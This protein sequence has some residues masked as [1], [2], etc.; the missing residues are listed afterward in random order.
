MTKLITRPLQKAYCLCMSQPIPNPT[1]KHNQSGRKHLILLIE[2]EKPIRRFVKPYLESK[3]FKVV[4]A[5]TGQ[6]GLS[7]ASSHKPDLILL[8][9]GLPDMDGLDVLRRLREWTKIPV[10]ILSARGKDKEKVE[11]L[12][13]GADDYLAKPFSV[14]E[15]MARI[16]VSLRH[17]F[18]MKQQG[19]EPVFQTPD[20]KV[21]LEARLVTVR[22]KETHLT[23]NEYEILAF[24]IRN[25]GK[26]VT[27]KQVTEE[28]WG[29]HSGNQESALRLYIHQLR[30]KLEADAALP[31]YILT[32]PG[33]GYRLKTK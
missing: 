17:L 23:P 8:D 1:R 33:V 5:V 20:F 26:V 11:G 18:D 15:L 32:E 7:L 30:Q 3:D 2:D 28:V 21:D 4:E 13:A 12:E 25:A 16:G 6:E 19:E 9:L 31:R 14:E 22:G 29:P 24:L 10:L 27:L